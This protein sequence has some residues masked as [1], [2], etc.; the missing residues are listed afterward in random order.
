MLSCITAKSNKNKKKSNILQKKEIIR[1]NP[2][3]S[4]F[5]KNIVARSTKTTASPPMSR[6]SS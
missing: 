5:L 6:M 2:Y 1:K 3:Y 4:D